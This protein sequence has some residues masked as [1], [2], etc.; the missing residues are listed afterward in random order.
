MFSVV[1]QPVW[2]A[3]IRGPGRGGRREAFQPGSCCEESGNVMILGGRDEA[4]EDTGAS[5]WQ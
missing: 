3:G 1:T 2:A 4:V 5:F